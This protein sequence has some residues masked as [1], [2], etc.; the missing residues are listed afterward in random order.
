MTLKLA[1]SNPDPE[2]SAAGQGPRILAPGAPP[3]PGPVPNELAQHGALKRV[4]VSGQDHP[5]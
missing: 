2:P 1:A 3:S 4:E 5:G